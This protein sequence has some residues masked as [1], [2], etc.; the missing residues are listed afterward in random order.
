MSRHR[1]Q[2][3][4]FGRFVLILFAFMCVCQWPVLGIFADLTSVSWAVLVPLCLLFNALL[5]IRIWYVPRKEPPPV[6]FERYWIWGYFAVAV[7]CMFGALFAVVTWWFPLT[8]MGT[9]AGLGCCLLLGLYSVGLPWRRVCVRRVT[10]PIAGLPADFDG[11]RIV[12]I[13]DLHAGPMSP[14]WRMRSW[15]RRVNALKPDY[16]FITGDVV[17]TGTTF[18]PSL[19]R[20]FSLFRDT[21]KVVACMGNHDYFGQADVAL[22][23]MYERLGIALLCNSHMPLHSPNQNSQLVLA[24]VDDTWKGNDDLDQAMSGANLDNPTLLLSHDPRVFDDVSAQQKYPIALQFS[25]HTH[26]GQLAI[27]FLGRST[28]VLSVFGVAWSQGLYKRN[29][30]WLHVSAGLGT[31]GAPVRIGVPSELSLIQLTSAPANAS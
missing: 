25:G 27:P 21:S 1:S 4:K 10:V 30:R 14:E 29:Q 22:R 15:I 9:W 2:R 23:A 13:S 12:H 26:G 6:W 19:E 20:S 16:V 8:S 28:S 11:L 3:K 7:S 5:L 31:T 18:V 17:A 24:A